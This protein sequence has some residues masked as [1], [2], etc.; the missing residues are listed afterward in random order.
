MSRSLGEYGVANRLQHT[1]VHDLGCPS[2]LQQLS[3]HFSGYFSQLDAFRGHFPVEGLLKR[4]FSSLLKSNDVDG[5]A[6]AGFR[7]MLQANAAG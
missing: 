3:P 1:V 5:C 7:L 4:L 2:P 6:R